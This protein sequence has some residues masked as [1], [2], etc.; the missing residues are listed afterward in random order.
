IGERES[1]ES[2]NRKYQPTAQVMMAGSKWRHLNKGGLGLHTKAS[3]QRPA[4]PP[5]LQHFRSP[6]TGKLSA[7][8]AGKPGCYFI[9]KENLRRPLRHS[10]PTAT[11]NTEAP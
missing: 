9:V 2:E 6:F 4:S 5:D 10:L 1:L 11:N 7:R 3:Y 8:P